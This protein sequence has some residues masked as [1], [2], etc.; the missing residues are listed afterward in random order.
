M[1]LNDVKVDPYYLV[2]NLF[3]LF[4]RGE[5]KVEYSQFITFF[6]EFV[7]YFDQEDIDGFLKEV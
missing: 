7:T 4:F 6:G 2:F 5:E 1:I 3:Q